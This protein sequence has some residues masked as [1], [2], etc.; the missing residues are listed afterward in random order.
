MS[1]RRL[2]SRSV[3]PCRLASA[4][5]AGLLPA[6]AW[7]APNVEFNPQFL[8]GE[9]AGALD[10]SRFERGEDLPGTYSAD[11][12]VNGVIVA[13]REVELR[14]LD[15][16]EV[17]ICLSP[18]VMEVLGV[19][20]ARL[21]HPDEVVDAKGLPVEVRPLPD[22]V[23]C[24]ALSNHVPQATVRFDAG[25][26]VLD[27]TIPQAYLARDPRGW[28][29]PELWD[30]GIDA[31]LL[32]YS[33]SHQR[34]QGNGYARQSSSAMLN[35]G[36]N[37]G[38]WRFRHD[39]YF[40]QSS[41]SGSKY[42]AGRTYAQRSIASWGVELL[43]GESSTRGDL[44][45]GV[46]FRGIGFAT[47]P[48]MLPDSQRDY[49][50]VVRGVAQ[51]NARVVIRQRDNVLYQANVAAGPFEINDLYG[52]AYAGDLDVE[53]IENDG[54]VQRFTVPFAAVPQLL[55]AGQ[56]RFGV[57]AGTLRDDWL[58]H[59]PAFF[60][61]T[62][63]RGIDNRFTAYGGVTGSDGYGAVLAG[64]AL[65]TAIGAFSGDITFSHTALPGGLA[66]LGRS[67]QGQSYRLSYSK[68]FATTDTT[69]SMAA[70]RYSTDGYLTLNEASRLRQQLAAGGDGNLI[71]RQ[72]SR[73]ELTVNQ[74][75]GDRGGSLYA[76]GSSMDYW[77]L[78]RRRTNFAVGY[79]N[80][81]G[82]A[83][84]SIS[85]QRSL[86]RTLGSNA[87]REGNSLYFNLTVPLDRRAGAPRINASVNRRGDR[88]D[89][90]RTGVNGS[91][92][93]RRQGSY[94]AAASRY[95][96]Q[97]NSYDAGINYQAS[98]ASLSAGYSH[99]PGSRGL[100]LGASGGVV[101]HAGGVAFSQQLGDTIALVH[102]PDAAGAAI[103]STV[104]VKINARG[105]A[106]VPYMTP[107]R[108]N[109]VTID[110][111]GLPM[112]VELKTASVVGVP[113]AG[114]VV[115]LVVPTS[116]GR[117]A[118]IEAPLID[119]SPLPFGIDV[120]DEAGEVVGVVGQASRLWV[121]GIEEKGQL[122]VR[123]GSAP[124]RQCVIDFDLASVAPGTMLA[125]QCRERAD[126]SVPR[127]T[128]H[129]V[130]VDPSR[131][132]DRG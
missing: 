50:P 32:G 123:W 93:E 128:A 41:E 100:S 19:D 126:V 21:P 7:A 23:I 71:A 83:S 8:Q 3:S 38:A 127:Q 26:Q 80:S 60:E 5:V 68:N 37:L 25:E 106:V 15:N 22:T 4:V 124:A 9:Q 20:P 1:F 114:A 70:Y 101:A 105:Y 34:T 69:L 118:L 131:Q 72:R 27:I 119:G 102:V 11:I 64:G 56:Q 49:A 57:T 98:M 33:I 43:V 48:R 28:V 89:D 51:T 42:R 29:S 63:R 30:D 18:Q 2:P 90:I 129:D 65:N 113:T 130:D 111:R 13:R 62:L 82:I 103:D 36:V 81:I 94:S 12:R 78:A 66:G 53:V 104:G 14:A 76:S 55:R 67:M 87:A 125:G 17:V 92:G 97:G 35:A 39:G 110:P 122:T 117:S 115:K 10:L 6:M 74:R 121:R 88:R 47:D 109:E 16:G 116:S 45:E 86:E 58:R 107:F 120:Y 73:L 84:Y 99:S 95:G 85:A 77:N 31:A 108:R 46:N 54:R 96:G 44:F 59:E 91:F 61:A 24:D 112:D 132:D 52:T 79:S 40:S 75:L